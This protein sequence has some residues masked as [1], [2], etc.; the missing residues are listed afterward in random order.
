MFKLQPNGDIT[1]LKPSGNFK[2]VTAG[3]S[4]SG[5]PIASFTTSDPSAGPIKCTC[6]NAVSS[7]DYVF[8]IANKQITR[9]F[10][11]VTVT[12]KTIE[13]CDVLTTQANLQQSFSVSFSTSLKV[14]KTSTLNHLLFKYQHNSGSPGYLRNHSLK[15]GQLVT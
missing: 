6:A 9:V 12:D 2:C 14:S 3:G 11:D 10:A 7:V 8:Q 1:C 13:N 4:I 5:L 15:V